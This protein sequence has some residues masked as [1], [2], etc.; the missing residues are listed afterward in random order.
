MCVDNAIRT[1]WRVQYNARLSP[2][3][4][5]FGDLESVRAHNAACTYF[6]SPSRLTS[7]ALPFDD[8][9]VTEGACSART[10]RWSR[11]AVSPAAT[12]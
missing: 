2:A 6:V 1:P 10:R 4:T 11:R 5:A 8:P 3:T 12:D 7:V 9:D